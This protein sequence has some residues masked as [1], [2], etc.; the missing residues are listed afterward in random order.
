M[1]ST[2]SP[3]LTNTLMSSDTCIIKIRFSV[4]AFVVHVSN[5]LLELFMTISR[6]DIGTAVLPCTFKANERGL[7]IEG[8]DSNVVGL[9]TAMDK[10]FF[11]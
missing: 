3:A 4:L 7:V 11:M 2:W 6:S 1:Y 8:I 5:G 10:T 9:D